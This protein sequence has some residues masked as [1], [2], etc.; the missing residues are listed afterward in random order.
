MPRVTDKT[1]EELLEMILYYI[2]RM[3]K[4]DKWRTIGGTIRSL[5]NLI[6]I[7]LLI[8]STWY[9]YQH[10]DE[11]IKMITKS[12]TEQMSSFM[13]SSAQIQEMMEGI[14]R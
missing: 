10:G 11:F 9:F 2:Q 3:E 7:I 1:T 6:P 5:I 12:M 14:K 8:L 13:P 4:R